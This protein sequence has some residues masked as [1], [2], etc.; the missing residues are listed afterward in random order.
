MRITRV[1][2][3]ELEGELEYDGELW[4]ERVIRP[5]DVYPEHKHERGYPI[6][7]GG[8]G[9]ERNARGAY[10]ITSIFVSVE[11]DE[12]VSGLAGSI[13]RQTAFVIDT[14]VAPLVVGED[15][16]AIERVWDKLYR[17]LIHAR[18]GQPMFAISALDVALWDLKGKWLNQP[19]YRL[20]GGPVRDT[21]PAY[22]SMLGYSLEPD[23][24][25]ARARQVVDAGYSAT[26]WFMRHGPDDGEPG[27][28]ANVELART[29]RA[30]VGDDVEVML[31]AW[32]SWNARY[33]IDMAHRLAEYRPRWIEEPVKPDDI[34]A[35]ARIRA[36]SPVPIAGGEHEYTRWGTR[37][38]MRAGAV[39]VFQPDT[40]WAGGI[41]EMMKMATICSVYDVPLVPHGS[42][43]PAN[44]HISAALPPTLCPYVEY[45]IKWNDIRQLH[46]KHKVRPVNGRIGPTNAPGL[47]L[48]IDESTITDRRELVLARIAEGGCSRGF[49][50]AIGHFR[51]RRRPV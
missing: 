36:A 5:I 25:T 8:L 20:L 41:S 11:T 21:I 23:R 10:P 47:G 2:L 28:R 35:Y 46:L 30:A 29:V 15:P 26:K 18:K 37:D 50:V 32:N 33:T 44:V 49:Q 1:R 48:E 3:I 14:D 38:Y 27:A 16:L 42:F 45:L 31:D 6:A 51:I 22:A 9:Q 24:V 40:M 13:D 43:V 7:R 4:E 19:V 34:P 39:D 17:Q 12:G